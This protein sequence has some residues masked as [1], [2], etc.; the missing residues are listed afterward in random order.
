M[1]MYV[2]REEPVKV[3]EEWKWQ[4]CAKLSSLLDPTEMILIQG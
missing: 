2:S 4:P 3:A 1:D